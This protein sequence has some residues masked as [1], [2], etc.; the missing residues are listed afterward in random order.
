MFGFLADG[1]KN[2]VN[3]I[4]SPTWC[5]ECGNR[6]NETE[7]GFR[8]AGSYYAC[9]NPHCTSYGQVFRLPLPSRSRSGKLKTLEPITDIWTG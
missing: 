9:V 5:R 1:F 6:L 3:T 2:L 7:I 4:V 8:E